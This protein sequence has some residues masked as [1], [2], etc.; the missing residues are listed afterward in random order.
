[1]LDLK[2]VEGP[3]QGAKVL[4]TGQSLDNA[5]RL[6]VLVHG[7]GSNA[8]SMVSLASALHWDDF[9][10]V[11]PS[12][13]G[14]TWYPYGFMEPMQANEPYLSSALQLLDVLTRDLLSAGFNHSQIVLGGWSQGACLASEFVARSGTPWGGLLVFSGGLIGPAGTPRN[15][16]GTLQ[17]M[18]VFIGCSDID[19]H[20]PIKRVNESADVL[21]KMGA[22]VEKVIYPNMGHT[23]V[24]DEIDRANKIL[25][26]V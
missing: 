9:A 23:I 8:Q 2:T 22:D 6:M 4:S 20:I 14:N 18:P 12:A 24:Q 16:T 26:R 5:E 21:A 17:D 13:V 15:Y 7:R 19:F 3:H 1:M 10:Y 25:M 11:L